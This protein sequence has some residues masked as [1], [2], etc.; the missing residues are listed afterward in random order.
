M[1]RGSISG[2]GA[3]KLALAIDTAG[4]MYYTSLTF[5]LEKPGNAGDNKQD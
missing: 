3:K 5:F 1:V 2:H 4:R